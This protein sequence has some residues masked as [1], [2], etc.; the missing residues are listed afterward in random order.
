LQVKTLATAGDGRRTVAIILRTGEEFTA[1][2][3]RVVEDQGIEAASFTAIGAFAEMT[4][5]YVGRQAD[6]S[7]K[8][9]AHCVVATATGEARAGH[10][11]EAYVRPTLEIILEESPAHLARRHDEETG[12][13]LIDLAASETG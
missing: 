5:G 3:Q 4:L 2:L 9:H 1:S 12:L 13:A 8:L 7:P 10:V 6:G 11:Q